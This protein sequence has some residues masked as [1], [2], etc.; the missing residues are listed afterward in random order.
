MSLNKQKFLNNFDIEIDELIEKIIEG[1]I[2]SADDLL[3][4]IQD[5]ELSEKLR[6]AFEHNPLQ[7]S[8]VITEK[9][10]NI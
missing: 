6:L 8:P 9:T 7:G 2:S 5:K 3:A 10:K 1:G 4:V